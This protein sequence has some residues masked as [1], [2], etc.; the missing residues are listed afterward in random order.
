MYYENCKQHETIVT[1]ELVQK[2]EQIIY[3]EVISI[4]EVSCEFPQGLCDWV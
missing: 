2:V 4:V 1:D 3:D